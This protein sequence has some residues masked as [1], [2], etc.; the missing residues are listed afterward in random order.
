M[1][2]VPSQ[3]VL[4]P[5]EKDLINMSVV[6]HSPRYAGSPPEF[7]SPQKFKISSLLCKCLEN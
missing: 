1:I 3:A 5:A 4:D 2:C 6:A 7:Y